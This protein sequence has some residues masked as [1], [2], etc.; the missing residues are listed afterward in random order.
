MRLCRPIW[1]LSSFPS[2]TTPLL[3]SSMRALWSTIISALS[4][5]TVRAGIWTVKFRNIRKLAKPFR[6]VK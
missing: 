3:S 5:S 2:W 6:K 1:R 4:Q